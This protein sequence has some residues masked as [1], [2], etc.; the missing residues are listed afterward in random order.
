MIDN[1][2]CLDISCWGGVAT[3]VQIHLGDIAFEDRSG[4]VIILNEGLEEVISKIEYFIEKEYL[5]TIYNRQGKIKIL[6]S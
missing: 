3:S 2:G 5:L 4:V 6:K 1:G